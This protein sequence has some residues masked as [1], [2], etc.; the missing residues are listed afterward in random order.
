[1]FNPDRPSSDS[2][3][4]ADSLK[5]W[6]NDLLES[7]AAPT[8][9]IANR[10]GHIDPAFIRRFD[11]VL[12]L[13]TPPLRN[14][15]ALLEKECGGL[16]A[17]ARLRRIATVDAATPAVLARAA[18]VMRRT[19]CS[20]QEAG[21]TLETLL[22]G[23]LQAQG[24]K[25]LKSLCRHAASAD[26][27]PALCNASADLAALADGLKRSGRGRVLLYGPPGTGKTAFGHW[28]AETLSKPLSLK[29]MSDLQSP[30]LGV[31]EQNLA[32]AFD[33]AER[34]GAILQIDEVDGYLQDRREAVRAWETA[35]V[36]E[37]LTQLESC[38]GIFI[39]TTNL[40]GGLDPAA[41]RRFDYKVEVGY[42]R[43][44]QVRD[45]MQRKLEAWGIPLP[46][47]DAC[48]RRLAGMTKLTPGD[49][50][51]LER[52]HALTPFP[53]AEA[54]LAA[55]AEEAS[56]KEGGQRRMGFV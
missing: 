22:D 10:I 40:L 51:V 9:W 5:A 36:N 49:F 46:D 7:N 37:F 56:F 45:M 53:D 6:I 33:T 16:V 23:T 21:E 13:E 32:R 14:R 11:A 19:A 8:I 18:G 39:A 28:L 4:D 54:V 35:Q 26:Y 20:A 38:S 15:L 27:D 34:D 2:G 44:G 47:E 41:L 12:H 3:G 1:V 24:Y 42:M 25:P 17:P 29:R 48:R 52:R 50:A 55:L 30:Y 31:M 43:S